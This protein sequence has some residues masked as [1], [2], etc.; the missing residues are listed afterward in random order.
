MTF[1]SIPFIDN[2][3]DHS[4]FIS[5]LIVIYVS[6]TSSDHTLFSSSLHI[7]DV[8]FSL[9]IFVATFTFTKTTDTAFI[10]ITDYIIPTYEDH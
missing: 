10:L 5:F 4:S 7:K 8:S 6:S 2:L 1:N 3:K 9:P